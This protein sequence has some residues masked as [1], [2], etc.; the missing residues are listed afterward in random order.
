MSEKKLFNQGKFVFIGGLAMGQDP[1]S[2]KKLSET[3]KWFKTRLNVGVKDTTNSQFLNMEYIHTDSVKT[4]KI[5]GKDGEMFEVN[6]E[7]T[8]KQSTIDKASDFTKIIID[9]ETDFEKKQEYTKLIYK[10]RNHEKENS[11]LEK[12]EEKTEAD[13][14]KI[15]E[16]NEKIEEYSKQIKELATNRVEFVHMKDVIKYLNSQL[17]SIKDKKLKVSGNVKSNYY[18]GKNTLQ[19]IPNHIELVPEDTENQL[20][21][22]IDVFYEKDSIDDDK[23]LKKMIVNGYVGERIKK[24]DKLYPITVVIDYTKVDENDPTHQALLSFMKDTFKITD[25]KQVHKI[26]VELNVINGAE[27]IEFNEDCLTEKQKMAISLGLNKLEDF[28]PRGNTYGNRI[29][30]LRVCKPILKGDFTSGSLEV[31]PIKDLGD[32]LVQD[33]SDVSEESVKDTENSTEET[34]ETGNTQDLMAKLFG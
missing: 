29:V 3:S 5:L 20:K 34:K 22:F 28:K 13:T 25:K 15:K 9:L 19:Y 4:C 8:H 18:K 32:Y 16:N 17:P 2:M 10:I 30:E 1:M 7:D 6:L 23:K 12:K 11:E 31:F 24:A 21:V 27:I 26:N 33:D 14:N